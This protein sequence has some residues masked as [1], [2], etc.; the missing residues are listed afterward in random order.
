[1]KSELMTVDKYCELCSEFERDCEA[2]NPDIIQVCENWFCVD[3]DDMALACREM[4]LIAGWSQKQLAFAIGL[5][6]CQVRDR[7]SGRVATDVGHCK[8]VYSKIEKAGNEKARRAIKGL[9]AY[10][11]MANVSGL[12]GDALTDTEENVTRLVNESSGILSAILPSLTVEEYASVLKVVTSMVLAR[13]EDMDNDVKTAGKW[14]SFDSR[15]LA[16]SQFGEEA[17]DSFLN[18]P[19]E[20]S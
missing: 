6:E 12:L 16:R 3:D 8:L 4:R 5:S 10:Y 11:V 1:M 7:E 17:I 9:R 19:K 14:L 15:Q 2:N 20:K 13:S 18:Y